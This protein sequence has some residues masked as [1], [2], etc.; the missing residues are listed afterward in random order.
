[1]SSPQPQFG[2]PRQPAA[3]GE[4]GQENRG[5]PNEAEGG[6]SRDATAAAITS[7][8][9]YVSGLYGKGYELSYPP[10][11]GWGAFNRDDLRKLRANGKYNN[12]LADRVLGIMRH[13]PYFRSGVPELMCSTYPADHYE[14]FGD[15]PGP[16][17]RR[18]GR[19]NART[20][21]R[22]PMKTTCRRISVSSRGPLVRRQMPAAMRSCRADT[23]LLLV[24]LTTGHP[25]RCYTILIDTELGAVRFWDRYDG[26]EFP[27][28]VPGVLGYEDDAEDIDEDGPDSWRAA[29]RCRVSTFFDHWRRESLVRDPRS[30]NATA[31]LTSLGCLYVL[32]TH[33]RIGTRSLCTGEMEKRKRAATTAL[34]TKRKGKR[35]MHNAA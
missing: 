6:Y 30:C 23:C 3:A 31:L 20:C 29:P 4:R 8:F 25:W 33:H 18:V 11:G 14:R 19:R 1:M 28:S 5:Q 7:M 17:R 24:V 35:M 13:I 26:G 10:P 2:P 34:N 9:A 27:T 32:L 12:G 22:K 21:R 16:T 15:L